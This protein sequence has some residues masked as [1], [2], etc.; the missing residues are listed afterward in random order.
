MTDTRDRPAAPGSPHAPA[1]ATGFALLFMG[2][3]GVVGL[4]FGYILGLDVLERRD[5]VYEVSDGLREALEP[6]FLEYLEAGPGPPP[7]AAVRPAAGPRRR[8]GPGPR[9]R[10][11]VR[12]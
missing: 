4:T 2:F 3:G 7:G 9:D 6:A 8:V 11:G 10:R 5:P 12:G 1:A